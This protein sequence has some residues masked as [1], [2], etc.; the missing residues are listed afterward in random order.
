MDRSE[1]GSF[2]AWEGFLRDSPCSCIPSVEAWS[3]ASDLATAWQIGRH[4]AEAA[5]MLMTQ[6]DRMVV[7]ELQALVESLSCIILP[8]AE[9]L[10]GKGHE[11]LLDMSA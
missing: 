11:L 10:N 3:K 4:E 9:A 2:K 1:T 8:C 5:H 7:E 6:V